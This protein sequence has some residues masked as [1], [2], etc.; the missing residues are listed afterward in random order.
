[1]ILVSKVVAMGAMVKLT[2]LYMGENQIGDAGMVAFSRTI[3]NGSMGLLEVSAS[4]V[5]LPAC[6]LC[7]LLCLSVSQELNLSSNQIGDD[8]MKAFSTAISKGALPSLFIL[9]ITE[10][11]GDGAPAKKALAERKK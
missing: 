3:A 6:T 1:M 10:N 7:L 4:L 9:G 2:Y 8:G 5:H 11:P